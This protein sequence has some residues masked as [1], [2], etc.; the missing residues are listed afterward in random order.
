MIIIRSSKQVGPRSLPVVFCFS[1]FKCHGVNSAK[2]ITGSSCPCASKKNDLRWSFSSFDTGRRW[3][4]PIDGHRIDQIWLYVH[5][6]GN[7]LKSV[8]VFFSSQCCSSLTPMALDESGHYFPPL[9]FLQVLLAAYHQKMVDCVAVLNKKRKKKAVFHV[10]FQCPPPQWD[11]VNWPDRK[12][13]IL[14][15]LAVGIGKSAQHRLIA[16]DVNWPLN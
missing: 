16:L 4:F 7:D 2:W 3:R 8:V 12:K 11:S 1:E 5:R 15:Y 13:V 14:P 10:F 9:T 6:I